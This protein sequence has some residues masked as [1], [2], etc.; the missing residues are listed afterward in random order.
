[1]CSCLVR[2][3]KL[4]LVKSVKMYFFAK[5]KKTADKY[6]KKNKKVK[7]RNFYYEYY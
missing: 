1:M 6:S 7:G 4:E 5:N 2:R 3:T